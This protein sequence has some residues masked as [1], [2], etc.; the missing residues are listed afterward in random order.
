MSPPGTGLLWLFISDITIEIVAYL[1]SWELEVDL[2]R[3]DIDD[4]IGCVE[5]HH[6]IL[7]PCLEPRSLLGQTDCVFLP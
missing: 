5:E 2:S 7:Q 4:C 6:L 1:L 3:S